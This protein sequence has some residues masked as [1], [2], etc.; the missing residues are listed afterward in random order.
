MSREIVVDSIS[1]GENGK[2]IAM[3]E[4]SR[5]VPENWVGFKLFL[6]GKEPRTVVF[7][8]EQARRIGEALLKAAQRPIAVTA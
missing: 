4:I 5:I 1:M 3:T 6:V 2:Q 8:Q 7:S